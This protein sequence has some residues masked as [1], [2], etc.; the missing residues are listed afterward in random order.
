M[1]MSYSRQSSAPHSKY[2][3]HSLEDA[4]RLNV[5]AE[6]ARVLLIEYAKNGELVNYKKLWD[7][8]EETLECPAPE[9]LWRKRTS[10][11]LYRVAELNRINEEPLLT[12]LVILKTTNEV[13][14]GYDDGVFAR[15]GYMTDDFYLHAEAEQAKCFNWMAPS[16]LL[17][18]WS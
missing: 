1:T 11:L 17:E 6:G 16:A 12:S 4:R 9:G 7:E 2:Q 10:A 15:Y 18:K 8:L 5:W 3:A 13:S 14:D